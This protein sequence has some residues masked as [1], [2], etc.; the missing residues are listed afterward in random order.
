MKTLKVLNK[1]NT[2]TPPIWIMRQAGRYLKEFQVVKKKSGGFINMI[3]DPK[4]ISEITIQPIKKFGFDS[5]II[6]SD[7]LVIPDSLGQR[8]KYIEGSGPKL[9]IM[10]LEHMIKNLCVEKNKN[11]LEKIY[12]GIKETKKK[13]NPDKTSLI[14]FVGAPLTIAFFMLDEKKEKNYKKILNEL[15]LKKK[16]TTNLFKILEQAI[17]KHAIKQIK[18]GADIIQVFDTWATIVPTKELFFFSVDP[19][20]RICNSIKK[21]F[22]HVPIIVFPR[23]VK[24]NYIKY[25]LPSIDC[26]SVG[27]D[28]TQKQIDQIQKQ[29]VIQGNLK[30]KTLL[31]G[32][33]KLEIGVSKVFEK[34]SKKPFIF[35]LSHGI[36][37]KTPVKN[38]KKLIK[39][40]RNYKKK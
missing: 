36:L 23:N 4:I 17:K 7:I 22:P 34:F 31:I 12:K 16:K 29:K 6:F 19:I 2:Y 30:P 37:P 15:K 20:K 35:N 9:E 11:K 26:I 39:L 8:L 38:V 21:K 24:K 13:I 27:D 33:K 40:V 3:Y 5:A 18:A 14:G 28:I 25:I 1:K 32:G 10:K